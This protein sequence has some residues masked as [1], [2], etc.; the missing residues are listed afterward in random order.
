MNNKI[1]IILPA[2]NEEL[3]IEKT[4]LSFNKYSPNS[5]IVV[6]DN[7]SSDKTY[8][9]AKETFEKNQIDGILLLEKRQGKGNAIRKAF[10]EIDADIYVM[11]DADLTY[12]ANEINKII[13]PILFENIDM[14]VGDRISKGDYEKENKRFLHNFGNKLVKNLVNKL[15]KSDINDIMSGYRAFSKKFVKHYPILV[16][17]FEL[18]TDMTLHALDK[19]FNIKEVPITY[20]DRPEGSFSKLNT[21]NDGFKVLFTIFKIFRYFKPFAFFSLLSS[22]FVFFSII[23]SIPVFDDWFRYK[24]IFHVPLAIL[25]TGLGLI[26]MILFAVALILDAISDQ[27]RREFEQRILKE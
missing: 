19:R 27:N 7:N 22:I 26:S 18:E 13:D 6:V 1:A 25:S 4:I 16:E 5:K 14:C 24:Y 8:E 20:K 2:Y 15:F 12:P 9:I 10:K 23:S 3:T 17:G 21:F 11:S